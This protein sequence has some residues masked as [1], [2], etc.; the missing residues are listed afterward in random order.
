MSFDLL[1]PHGVWIRANERRQSNDVAVWRSLREQGSQSGV[2]VWATYS[3]R[4]AVARSFI[5]QRQHSSA[6][7]LS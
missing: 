1:S 3:G 4:L 7:L 5:R 2:S 6:K